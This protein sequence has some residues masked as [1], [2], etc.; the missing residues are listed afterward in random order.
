MTVVSPVAV[1]LCIWPTC[2]NAGVTRLRDDSAQAEGAAARQRT[3]ERDRAMSD[4]TICDL[5]GSVFSQLGVPDP[6]RGGQ[7]RT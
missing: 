3:S 5:L 2:G 4:T 1:R 7:Q 6:D